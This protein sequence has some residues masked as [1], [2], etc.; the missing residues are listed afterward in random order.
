MYQHILSRILDMKM[1]EKLLWPTEGSTSVTRHCGHTNNYVIRY[2][3][4]DGVS[5]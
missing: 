4:N 2:E 1:F 3:A 5:E